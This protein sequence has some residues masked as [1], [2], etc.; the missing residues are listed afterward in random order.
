MITEEYEAKADTQT[1]KMV[2]ILKQPS[3]KFMMSTSMKCTEIKDGKAVYNHEK[4]ADRC[5]DYLREGIAEIRNFKGGT[6]TTVTDEVIEELDFH[7]IMELFTKI[8]NS[9]A[10]KVEERKN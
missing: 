2:F 1:P 3:K 7:V 9:V 4:A 10:L 8:M 6:V 5:F